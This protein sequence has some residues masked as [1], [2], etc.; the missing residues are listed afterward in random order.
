M[1]RFEPYKKKR[2]GWV[3]VASYVF[4]WVVL[5][6]AAA[7]GYVLGDIT[8]NK[9]PFQLEDPDISFPFT[10]K[11]TVPTWLLVT[12][13][14][15]VPIVVVFIIALCFVPG[16]T[17]PAGTPK[18]LIW[19]RK[20]WELHAGWLGLA[21]SVVAA[22]FITSGMKNL[23]G[24]P[25]PDML[26]RCQPDLANVA[27]YVVGGI[28][29]TTSN[30]Q[31]V[32]ADICTSTDKSKLDDGFRSYPSGHSSSSAA[33]LIYLSLFIA[34]KFAITIPFLAPASYANASSFS[35]FPSRLAAP[36]AIADQNSYELADRGASRHNNNNESLSLPSDPS[37]QKR[38]ASHSRT[39]AA[40]R[41]QAAAPPLYLLVICVV[42]WFLSI[43]IASSRWF[44]FRHHG[45]DI[46]F[47]FLIGTVTAFFAFR[48]YHLPISQG[49]GWAWAPRSNDKA[50]WAGVGSYSYATDRGAWEEQQPELFG[51][52]HDGG[53]ASAHYGGGGGYYGGRAGDEEEALGGGATE[54]TG[55][56]GVTGRSGGPEDGQYRRK[57]SPSKDSSLGGGRQE[58][59]MGR[60]QD[61]QN[62]AVIGSAR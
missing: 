48:Y 29:N 62:A 59:E 26:A 16:S 22:W 18:S 36:G 44:D 34:S 61:V 13:A 40:A 45:F 58:V 55:A 7:V 8:P 46:L 37:A 56:A 4:D 24:K 20:L 11:E 38:L 1:D 35:A 2:V 25:R 3:L 47:G 41:R 39:V 15:I 10:E 5:I 43:F 30:G 9:R 50:L 19:K 12:L 21:L 51:L 28:A 54:Y 14:V 53:G 52:R 33:G 42:P 32:S 57:Q 49:A 6:A 31:L 60:V 17:V 27:R 23:F